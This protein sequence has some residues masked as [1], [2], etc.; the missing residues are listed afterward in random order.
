MN[1]EFEKFVEQVEKLMM[2]E[3]KYYQSTEKELN[4][5]CDPFFLDD[6]DMEG[7]CKAKGIPFE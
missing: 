2:A 4:E 6:T 5:I 1:R 3:E 7:Y